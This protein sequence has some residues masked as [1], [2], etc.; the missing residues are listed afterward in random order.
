MFNQFP[1]AGFFN[2]PP[3]SEKAQTPGHGSNNPEI[4]E[5]EDP[6]YR[7]ATDQHKYTVVEYVEMWVYQSTREKFTKG[8]IDFDRI[9]F[10]TAIAKRYNPQGAAERSG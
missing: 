4:G 10:C 6:T 2:Y 7:G 3:L 5:H 9:V 8:Y 1:N